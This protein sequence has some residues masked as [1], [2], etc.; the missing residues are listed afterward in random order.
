MAVTPSQATPTA[1][2]D[3]GRDLGSHVPLIF[4][5]ATAIVLAFL[6]IPIVIVVLITF[7][8][9]GS[10][11]LP[12]DGVSVHWIRNFWDS[13]ALRNSFLYSMLVSFL[14]AAVAT[15][16]GTMTALWLAD[17]LRERRR[18]AIA[19]GALLL[20]PIIM[21]GVA[22]GFALFVSY[23]E[24]GIPATTAGLVIVQAAVTVPFVVIIA[25]ASLY[26]ADPDLEMAARSLGLRPLA[27]FRRVTLPIAL[28]GISGG[29]LFAFL[30]SFGQGE[31]SRYITPI[32][33]STFPI[34]VY[35]YL[36]L[37]I[38]PTPAAG[39]TISIVMVIISVVLLNRLTPLGRLGVRND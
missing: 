4:K 7:N 12:V 28:P 20:I 8:R 11:T 34:A 17:A 22:L 29:F 37:Q 32:N 1:Q 36:T 10:F 31:L 26:T 2:V 38:D 5:V 15:V 24:L 21:P 18:S 16:V 14:A 27:A 13:A 39:G 35:S 3:A 33:H 9:S 19:A 6:L 23:H 30:V 25:T